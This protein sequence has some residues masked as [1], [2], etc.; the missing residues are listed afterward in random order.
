MFTVSESGRQAASQPVRARVRADR[1]E[2]E[3]GGGNPG[4]DRSKLPP[5]P[6]SVES[7]YVGSS[8]SVRAGLGRGHGGGGAGGDPGRGVGGGGGR[9][10][11]L[12][13]RGRGQGGASPPSSSVATGLTVREKV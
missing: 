9:G 13:G 7:S 1:A 8:V 2:R 4:C 11:L 3:V 10:H 12:P 6:E 5:R